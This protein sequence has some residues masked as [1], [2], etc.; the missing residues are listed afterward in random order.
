[1]PPSIPTSFFPVFSSAMLLGRE[2]ITTPGQ[3]PT[4]FTS[5]PVKAL[6]TSPKITWLKDQ[7]LRGSN[8]ETFGQAQGGRYAEITTPQS[9]AY[10]D[11]IG[12]PLFAMCG[13]YT[14]TGAAASPNST[15]NGGV[16]AGATSLTVASGTGF[17]ASQWIQIDTLANAEIVQVLS[18]ASNVITLA[19][20]TP[21][22]FSHLTAAPV[23]NTQAPYVHLFS[24]INPGSST[25][26][27]SAQPPTYT[28]LHRTGLPGAGSPGF[29]ADQYLYG[30]MTDL[31]LSAK[32]TDWLLWDSKITALSRSNPAA[33]Y[34]PAF[35]TVTGWPA[36]RGSITLNAGAVYNVSDMT[37]AMSRKPDII[38]TSDGQQDPYAIGAGPFSAMFTIDYDAVSDESAL[39]YA[40][41]NTQPALVYTISNGLSGASQLSL[42]IAAAL[43]AHETAD[44]AAQRTLWGYKTT[45]ELVSSTSDAGNSGGYSPFQATLTNAVPSY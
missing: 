44:L 29:S 27:A 10:A 39:N 45:G 2:G 14:V 40:L 22:R 12:H 42:S 17:A 23:T 30:H 28:V 31:K 38:W 5:I 18:V 20:N 34:A 37:I 24:G 4:A 16:A 1:M 15:L 43:A 33:N 6:T 26:N 9:L 13:D 19:T 8:V 36:W 25:G 3:A 11:T 21:T 41:N 32:A 7:N 35:S